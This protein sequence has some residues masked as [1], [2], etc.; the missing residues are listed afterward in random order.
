MNPKAM[1]QILS[2]RR[3]VRNRNKNRVIRVIRAKK[4]KDIQLIL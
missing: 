1:T 2:L 3:I 4:K